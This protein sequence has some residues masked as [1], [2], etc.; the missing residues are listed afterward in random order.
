MGGGKKKYADLVP[1][2]EEAANKGKIVIVSALDGTF[3]RKP[4]GA[5]LD[6]VPKAEVVSKLTA[7]CMI[8]FRDAA[9]S[10][11]IVQ[12]GSEVEVIGGTDK[13]ISVCRECFFNP[14]INS[15]PFKAAKDQQ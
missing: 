15:S 9:F 14:E 3:Q 12:C 5:V 4:F 7:V 8:C 11:R 10:K 2:C 6:L 13:Y 1:V